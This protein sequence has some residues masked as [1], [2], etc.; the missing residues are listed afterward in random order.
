MGTL[1]KSSTFTSREFNQD[2]ARA[3]RE[4]ANGPVFITDRGQPSLVLL[5]HTQYEKLMKPEQSIR[6]LFADPDAAD[7]DL[8]LSKRTIQPPRDLNLL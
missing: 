8:P 1:K 6:K 5:S 7:I 2:T 3:K 4:A